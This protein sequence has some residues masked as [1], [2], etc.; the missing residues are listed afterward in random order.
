MLLLCLVQAVNIELYYF[1]WNGKDKVKRSTLIN[2]I[3]HGGLKM[4]DIECMIKAQIIIC[5]KKYIG[6]Y[7]SPWNFFL[8]YYL[9]K[10]GGK[11]A[12]KCQ[13]DSHKPPIFLPAFHK[14]CLDAWSVLTKKDVVTY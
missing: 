7:V 5:L 3:E 8:D 6:G 12:L 9:G 10:V 2:D 1:I 14:D 11:F 4:L 13:F